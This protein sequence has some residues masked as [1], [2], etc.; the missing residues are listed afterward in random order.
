MPRYSAEQIDPLIELFQRLDQL[1]DRPL[2]P[3]VDEKA[4]RDAGHMLVG[5]T[6]LNCIAC[7][8]F[9]QKSSGAMAAL[10]LTDMGNRLQSNWFERYMGDPQRW[11]PGTVMPSFW[12]GGRALRSD[13]LEGHASQQIDALWFYLLDGRQ[14]RTPQ[15]LRLE[16]MQLLAGAEAVMLRRSYPGVGK[17]GIGVGYPAELNLVFDAEQLRLATLWR[18]MFADPAGVWRSQGHGMVR[19]LGEAPIA[20]AQGPEL[21]DAEHPWIVDD[22][23]P[24]DHRF[25]GY[26]L[27]AMQRPIFSYQFGQV[28][29][30]DYLVDRTAQSPGQQPIFHRTL[31]F[32]GLHNQPQTHFRVA[33]DGRI[34]SISQDSFKVGERLVVRILPPN[35]GIIQKT[36]SGSDLI[37]KLPIDQERYQVVIEYVW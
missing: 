18:G 6:G 29:V 7:H 12:P 21:D 20:L 3:I 19:P 11:S 34:T 4:T 36:S 15:G 23:R 31:N 32:R 8:S 22:G 24:P 27:D 13:I 17:R 2:A 14:A 16:P 26:S 33:R 5:S 10:D 30:E 9:Q 25:L 35:R 37:V 1:P 28:T